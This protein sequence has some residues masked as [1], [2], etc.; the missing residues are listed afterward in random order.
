[1]THYQTR[2]EVVVDGPKPR[3]AELECIVGIPSEIGW[4][5]WKSHSRI[6]GSILMNTY[7]SIRP[8]RGSII[9]LGIET[10]T[11]LLGPW[12]SWIFSNSDLFV[13]G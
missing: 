4:A 2:D 10:G 13:E 6:E 11:A 3:R 9:A 5:C 12:R 1:M 8:S 7:C